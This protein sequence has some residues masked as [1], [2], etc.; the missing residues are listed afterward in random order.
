VAKSEPA[1]VDGTSGV[2]AADSD[3]IDEAAVANA[4]KFSVDLAPGKYVL[5][6]QGEQHDVTVTQAG[7]VSVNDDNRAAVMTLPGAVPAPR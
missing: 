5:T 4:D 6:Y 1:P 3:P 2:I 7:N